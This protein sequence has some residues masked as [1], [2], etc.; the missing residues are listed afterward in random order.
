MIVGSASAS[1]ATRRT[2][3]RPSR[4]GVEQRVVEGPVLG[5]DVGTSVEERAKRIGVMTAR[6]DHRRWRAVRV[7]CIGIGAI[8]KRRPDRVDVARPGGGQQAL[9]GVG[10]FTRGHADSLAGLTSR[11]VVDALHPR[12]GLG[13]LQP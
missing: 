5:I 12:G 10:G 3:R 13:T 6:R 11:H 8:G 9:V 2:S 7:A 1:F 4:A